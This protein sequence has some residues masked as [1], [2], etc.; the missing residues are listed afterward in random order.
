MLAR[1]KNKEE[2]IMSRI[3]SSKKKSVRAR[4]SWAV[5]GKVRPWFG[6]QPKPR[7]G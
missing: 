7:S 3:C 1:E 2:R 5:L 6:F 4:G